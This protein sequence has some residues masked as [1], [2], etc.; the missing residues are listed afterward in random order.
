MSFDKRFYGIYLGVCVDNNDPEK[1]NKIRLI[2]PQILG[3]EITEWA[4]PCVPVTFNADHP[5]HKKHLASEVAALL[6]GHGDHSIS[7]SGTT[8]SGGSPGHTHS[9]SAT[10]TLTHTNN[11]AGKTPDSTNFLDHEHET[12]VN[13]TK[14]WNGSSGT[15]FN[16]ATNTNEH[17]PH[18]GVPDLNQK[19]WVMFIA[20]DPNF[21]VWM[22]VL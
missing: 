11:H 7:I 19:V 9:F 21:P 14:K 16:D 13:T 15:V 20:G 6:L 12:A 10:Q 2:V 4:L 17:T 5:D 8:G 18:R 3:Q 22:G 1:E